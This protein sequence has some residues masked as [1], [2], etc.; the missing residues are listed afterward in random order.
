[1]RPVPA[2]LCGSPHL[3]VVRLGALRERE[4]ERTCQSSD[5]VAWSLCSLARCSI[6]SPIVAR[7]SRRDAVSRCSAKPP[8]ASAE[9][10]RKGGQRTNLARGRAAKPASCVCGE[11][12]CVVSVRVW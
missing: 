10:M 3:P 12:A 11:C 8:A 4:R 1:M 7:C 5:M 6:H 9:P 2:A